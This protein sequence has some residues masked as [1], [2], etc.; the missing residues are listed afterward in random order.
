MAFT[1]QDETGL[2]ADANA[3]VSVLEFKAY[4]D[5]RG[6]DYSAFTD[7]QIE[8]AIVRATDYVD[9]RFAFIG[10]RRN[11][12]NPAQ[13]TEWPRVGVSPQFD[14][15]PAE[16]KEATSEYALR[17]LQASLLPDPDQDGTGQRLQS[18][19]V[20]AGSVSVSKTYFAG[21]ALP[22]YPQADL[23]LRRAGLLQS[24]TLGRA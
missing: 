6:G 16:V 15:I 21:G 14:G 18:K 4:H 12:T 10:R 8:Q 22:T 19:S 7:T 11:D 13:A 23:K 5:D 17:A 9:S 20:Q 3:Y 2:V 24:R 1:V